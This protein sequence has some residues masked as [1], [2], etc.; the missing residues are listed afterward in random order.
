MHT[1]PLLLYAVLLKQVVSGDDD[2][3]FKAALL[4]SHCVVYNISGHETQ[5]LE[6]LRALEILS[7]QGDEVAVVTE[8]RQFVLVSSFMTWCSGPEPDPDDGMLTDDDY[9]RRQ[10]HPHYTAHLQ[11]E[12]AVMRAAKPGVL[13]PYILTTGLLYGL[14]EGPFHHMFR[15]A[16]R[17]P[18]TPLVV[19]GS[20]KNVVPT[21]HIRDLVTVVGKVVLKRPEQRHYILC[22]DAKV[23]P[24]EMAAAVSES[25]GIGETRPIDEEEGFLIPDMSQLRLDSLVANVLMGADHPTLSATLGCTLGYGEGPIH[26]M[27]S[28][29]NDFLSVRQLKPLRICV[30]G[31]PAVG[32]TSVAQRLARYYNVTHVTEAMLIEEG[33]KGLQ[34]KAALLSTLTPEDQVA[35]GDKEAWKERKA[36][37]ED[38]KNKVE[39]LEADQSA[40]KYDEFLPGW[41]KVKMATNTCRVH[42]YV[43][44][45]FPRTEKQACELFGDMPVSDTN[46]GNLPDLVAY[47]DA[48]DD[49]LKERVVN[50]PEEEFSRLY[51]AETHG[52]APRLEQYHAPPTDMDA[53]AAKGLKLNANGTQPTGAEMAFNYFTAAYTVD[54][55]STGADDGTDDRSHTSL[56]G[57]PGVERI[58]VPT[59]PATP[60][61]LA[62]QIQARVGEPRNFG[63]PRNSSMDETASV[64]RTGKLLASNQREKLRARLASI[65]NGSD[66]PV[67]SE[68]YNRQ[69]S[70]A[71]LEAVTEPARKYMMKHI[72][73]TLTQALVAVAS[74]KPADPIKFISEFLA[75]NKKGPIGKINP[76]P[77]P[78]TAEIMSWKR[79]QE[80]TMAAK[81]T[82]IA[83]AEVETERALNPDAATEQVAAELQGG[84]KEDAS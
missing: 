67:S 44:D 24:L 40:R 79:E 60:D 29:V 8:G 46:K 15:Q 13:E 17:Q 55:K 54:D 74:A 7:A 65:R 59:E 45:D 77:W 64:V 62:D 32:K 56:H 69:E 72:L 11:C 35:E 70:D 52:I 41:L 76:P 30:T 49:F 58:S 81:M 34:D 12:K 50:M 37:I 9:I 14:G 3:A 20:G 68:L 18:D 6:A 43:I 23:T 5:T 25:F 16:W 75:A 1:L 71:E 63:T 4:S 26:H 57:V 82:A 61:E 83:D 73:P 19:I 36:D 51:S 2:G 27:P 80:A 42:G 10:A 66:T 39:K 53:K 28:L 21:L 84:E 22:D 33:T 31:P 47:L 48:S 38:A 78:R